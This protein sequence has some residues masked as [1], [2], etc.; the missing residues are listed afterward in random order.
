MP[1]YV[2]KSR[3]Y[4]GGLAFFPKLI[5]RVK[6][7]FSAGK[8]AAKKIATSKEAQEVLPQVFTD[9]GRKDLIM[10][11]AKK[12]AQKL[13]SGEQKGGANVPAKSS[14]KLK[15]TRKKK[16]PEVWKGVV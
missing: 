3:M 11:V 8:S 1:F 6:K 16:T 13:M 5:D 4:G 14:E 15:K 10:Q 12:A 2:G 9:Q 7:I